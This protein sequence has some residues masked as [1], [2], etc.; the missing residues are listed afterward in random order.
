MKTAAKISITLFVASIVT[1]IF[2]LMA[3]FVAS[4]W[5]TLNLNGFNNWPLWAS[6]P[7]RIGLTT[8]IITIIPFIIS[9]LYFV[10]EDDNTK[11]LDKQ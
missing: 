5:V 8:F 9:V 3:L 7:F 10:I 1:I 6:L 4:L 2:T 11:Q